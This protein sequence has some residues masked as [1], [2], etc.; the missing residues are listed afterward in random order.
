AKDKYIGLARIYMALDDYPRAL[1]AVRHVEDSRAFESFADAIS[2]A[3]LTGQSLFTYWELPKQY[4]LNRCLLETGDIGGARAGYDRLI[5]MPQTEQ[6]GDI[7]WIILFDRGRIAERENQPQ[8][9][10]EFYRRAVEIVERQRATITSEASK[11]GFAGNKQD[12]YLRT[13]S[14]LFSLGRHRDAF[15]YAERAKARA[16]VDMLA[17]RQ[18][19]ALPSENT[20]YVRQTL[21]RLEQAEKASRVE[22]HRVSTDSYRK[23][24]GLALRLKRDL[25]ETAPDLAS[26]VTVTACGAEEIRALLPPDEALVEYYC[27][28]DDLFAFVLTRDGLQGRKLTG[29]RLAGDVFRFRKTLSDPSSSGYLEVSRSLYDRLIAPIEGMLDRR[30]LLIVPHGALHY[31]PFCALHSGTE[32]L[33]DSHDI[34]MLPSSSVL[35][36]LKERKQRRDNLFAVGNPDLGDPRLDLRFAQE[37]AWDIAR[38]RPDATLLLR[39]QATETAVKEHAS[40]FKYLHFATHGKFFPED[41]LSSGLLLARDQSNDGMLTVAEL[42]TLRL[43]ADLVTLS[44]CETALGR[45][46]N[47]DDVVGFT[48]GFLYAGASSIVS[49][50]WSVDDR[51]T[52]ELMKQFYRDLDGMG[53]RE[54]LLSAQRTVRKSYPHPFY[55]AAFQIT[56]TAR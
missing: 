2:G 14:A 56:G 13:I 18:D 49:S 16:L 7:Y 55:W 54:A 52:C 29:E 28:G 4:I 42:Y 27:S 1:E 51:A 26:L 21:E 6:N 34:R 20:E 25:E 8:Q 47:G 45:V 5:E 12:L 11:I 23:Q 37:E 38:E 22:S 9:A 24:R 46:E 43:G 39:E 30:N 3:G 48:R 44:A 10:V 15:E 50:L 32:Y 17:A 53:K 33:I 36:F 35:R 19:L 41:P 40:D 31:L